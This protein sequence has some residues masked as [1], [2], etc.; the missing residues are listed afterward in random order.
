MKIRNI[1][2]VIAGLVTGFVIIVL[3]EGIV[4]AANPLPANLDM[5]NTESF[6]EY[7]SHAPASLHL[8]ILGIYALSC[9]AG[10]LVAASIATERKQNRAMTLGGILMGLGTF[11]LVSLG[12]PIWVVVVSFFVF[13]PFAWLGGRIAVRAAKKKGEDGK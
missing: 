4:H 12:H 7:I 1:L 10:G 9:F 11:N 2:S 6:K 8:S 13:L 3:G 5:T